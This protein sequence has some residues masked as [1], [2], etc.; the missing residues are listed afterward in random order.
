MKCR[1]CKKTTIFLHNLLHNN[2]SW[3]VLYVECGRLHLNIN[4]VYSKVLQALSTIMTNQCQN[5]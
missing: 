4:I 3:N 2:A 5:K 1:L